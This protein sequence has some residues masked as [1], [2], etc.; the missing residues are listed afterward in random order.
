MAEWLPIAALAEQVRSGS[1]KASDLVEKSLGII[2]KKSEYQAII[3]LTSDRARA[4]AKEI[5]AK[6]ANGEPVGKLAGVPFI[7]KDNFLVFG[8]ETTA[9]SNILKGF[10]APY[11]SSV[12]EK[13]EAEGALLRSHGGAVRLEPMRREF[14]AGAFP[15][16]RAAPPSPGDRA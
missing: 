2:E 4:R 9:A 1:V 12:I 8:A 10:E 7:A 16:T 5:D 11:Q 15:K 14:P 13:L 3:A 6:I